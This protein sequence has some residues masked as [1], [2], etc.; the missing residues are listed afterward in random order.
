[1]LIFSKKQ[2]V[3]SPSSSYSNI[4]ETL[5]SLEILPTSSTLLFLLRELLW[6]EL[7]LWLLSIKLSL[8]LAFD[9]ILDLFLPS[10]RLEADLL[11][12][13]LLPSLED[14]WGTFGLNR[15]PRILETVLV[16]ERFW[17]LGW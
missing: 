5:L 3:L 9:K 4:L 17:T 12:L 14:D 16:K 15:P 10:P 2:R 7:W 1:M 13:R 11:R 8:G 6:I